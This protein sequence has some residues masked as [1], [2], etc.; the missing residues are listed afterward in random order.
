MKKF[1]VLFF[2]AMAVIS[3]SAQMR[4]SRTFTKTKSNTEWILR[5]ALSINS[6]S[7]IDNINS[8]MGFDVDLAFN[9]AF[10]MSPLYWGMEF[11]IGTR[12]FGSDIELN[13]EK[14]GVTAYDVK[15]S[16][17]TM[18]YKVAVTE[19]F[20]LD[21]HVGAYASYD[22]ATSN[23]FEF[24]TKYDAGLQTGLGLWY[25]RINLD[26]MYQFGFVNA[27]EDAG[28]TSN[29]LIRLGYRF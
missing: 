7:G 29:F 1:L 27:G 28:K 23:D 3:A 24:D 12:G 9:K 20:R 19:D 13:G 2:T 25:K 26:F 8:K 15:L 14:V 11:G 22:F 4:T 17:F 16:P 5:A 21:P 18:G 6:L 10:G